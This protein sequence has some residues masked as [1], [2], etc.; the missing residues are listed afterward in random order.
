MVDMPSKNI[1]RCTVS[2]AALLM[3]TDLQF[4][5]TLSQLQNFQ[6]TSIQLFFVSSEIVQNVVALTH[7]FQHVS[8]VEN[9]FKYTNTYAYV[10]CWS[11]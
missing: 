5:P 10:L 8:H 3:K 4:Q 11:V 2:Y 7:F 6:H 9:T 1:S